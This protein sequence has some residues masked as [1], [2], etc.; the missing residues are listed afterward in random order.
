VDPLDRGI[1]ALRP[2]IS[3]IVRHL[4]FIGT[5]QQQFNTVFWSLIV[6]MRVAFALPLFLALL[7]RLGSLGGATFIAIWGIADMIL[8]PWI[9]GHASPIALDL[10]LT[11]HYSTFFAVGVF[12]TL[13]A[14]ELGRVVLCWATPARAALL[15]TSF[16]VMDYIAPFLDGHAARLSW[17]LLGGLGSAGILFSAVHSR[18]LSRI[19]NARLLLWLGNI[20]FSL[21]LCHVT[22]LLVLSATIGHQL[23]YPALALIAICLSL[24]LAQV[25]VWSVEEPA[26][27]LGRWLDTRY[28]H[29]SDATPVAA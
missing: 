27:R 20:S 7:R 1:V 26:R 6:E 8:L 10:Y 5:Y 14:A 2:G 28:M 4:L 9:L 29:R 12:L 11:L 16:L 25:L 24:L 22:V 21:Y 17:D 23:P 18:R 19:L 3:L 13:H 15:L